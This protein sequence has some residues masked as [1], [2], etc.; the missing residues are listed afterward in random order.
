MKDTSRS[1][2]RFRGVEYLPPLG[3]LIAAGLLLSVDLRQSRELAAA[4]QT[5]DDYDGDGLTDKQELVL[6]TSRWD[7]DS[8]HDGFNDAE[9]LARG[10]QALHAQ[11]QPGS[12]VL[13][14]GMTCRA[15]DD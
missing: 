13:D 11:S 9:E 8:D 5:T 3:I 12:N 1:T 10:S 14:A 4:T 2:S 7:V 6:G 15:E